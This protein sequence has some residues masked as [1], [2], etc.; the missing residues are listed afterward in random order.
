MFRFEYDRVVAFHPYE[1]H[2]PWDH[3]GIKVLH[4]DGVN[5]DGAQLQPFLRDLEQRL[6]RDAQDEGH[7][8]WADNKYGFTVVR[9]AERG[10][11]PFMYYQIR[12]SNGSM[13][14]WLMPG[15]PE[16][17]P[18]ALIRSAAT[19][20]TPIPPKDDLEAQYFEENIR[21]AQERQAPRSEHYYRPGDRVRVTGGDATWDGTV[22]WAAGAVVQ[23]DN[24]E[25]QT[26]YVAHSLVVPL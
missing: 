4:V 25:G 20:F 19:D 26:F 17:L 13:Y 23:V 16:G 6:L 18:K 8:V 21:R 2:Q 14:V 24:S 9:N 11:G 3:G 10:G 5:G 15:P 22:V 7:K 12:F 1:V